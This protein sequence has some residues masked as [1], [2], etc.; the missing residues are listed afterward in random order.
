MLLALDVKLFL[1]GALSQGDL[2]IHPE[3]WAET[4]RWP[5][6]KKQKYKSELELLQKQ[7]SF[8][9]GQRVPPNEQESYFKLI[10][11]SQSECIYSL[12]YSDKVQLAS[13]LHFE[14]LS[15]ITNDGPLQE[16]ADT[17]DKRVYNAEQILL[18]ALNE[19]VIT[20]PEA[21]TTVTKWQQNNE[22]IKRKN[23]PALKGAG[24]KLT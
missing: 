2:I 11:I 4:K 20:L 21:Q 9:A 17:F 10:D 19:T 12:G 23:I 22:P 24:L 5:R 7:L 13:V 16:V 3:V 18:E 14:D 1:K 8:A 15:L 6:H